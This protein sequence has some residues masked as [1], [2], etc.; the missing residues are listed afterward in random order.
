MD[1]QQPPKRSGKIRVNWTDATCKRCGS[2]NVWFE[3]GK[4]YC[5]D[6]GS[7]LRFGDAKPKE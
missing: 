7:R 5:E 6:C 1:E 4:V 2:D 3:F